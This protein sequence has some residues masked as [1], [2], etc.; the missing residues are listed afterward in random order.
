LEVLNLVQVFIAHSS[1]DKWLIDAICE[2][3]A[4]IGVTPYLAELED[5]TPLP[6][7]DKLDAAIKISNALFLIITSSAM[8]NPQTRDV[9]NW[10]TAT[11]RAYQKPVY[12]F[13]E[14]GVDVPLLI[15][16]ISVYFTFDPITRE[17]LKEMMER[18][19]KTAVE[20]KEVE[21]KG[22][23]AAFIVV[24]LLGVLF[25]GSILGGKK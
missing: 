15:N 3:L 23:A 2:N 21:D 1:K 6:L 5:P 11:A 24:S 9:L 10:E 22:K 17:S 20:L 14:R 12:V 19:H 8:Q 16:Y 13:A 18:V 25:L 7:P 4:I